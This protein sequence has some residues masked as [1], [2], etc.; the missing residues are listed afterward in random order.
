M[1]LPELLSRVTA[2]VRM[3]AAGLALDPATLVVRHVVNLGGFVR[4]S[5]SISDARARYHL[6]LAGDEE[7][8]AAL[9]RW[10]DLGD[11]LATRYRAPRVCGWLEV[12]DTPY[13]GLLLEHVEGQQAKLSQT[14]GLA[15]ALG[16]LLGRLH[17]DRQLAAR[18]PGPATSCCDA[19]LADYFDR[20]SE[21]LRVIRGRRPGFVSAETL[22][23]LAAELDRVTARVRASAAFAAPA[24][25]PVHGDLWDDNV[26]VGADGRYSLLDWDDLRLGDPAVDLARLPPPTEIDPRADTFRLTRATC[27][28]WL[29]ERVVLLRRAHAL[30]GAIDPLADW[31]E[32]EA[33]PELRDQIQAHKQREHEQALAAYRQAHR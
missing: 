29:S 8:H 3:L 5:L 10:H 32:A 21:E 26:L 30:D 4:I 14:P 22:A 20:L 2:Q 23:W 19:F 13:A 1:H 18:L 27:E 9:R 31:I 33:W 12:V 16:E 7:G 15:R 25:V 17:A 24:N 11:L 6:K 28:P